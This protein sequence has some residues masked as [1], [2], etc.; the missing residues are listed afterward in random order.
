MIN[1]TAIW[2]PIYATLIKKWMHTNT[3]CRMNQK[4]HS[5]IKYKYLVHH[6]HT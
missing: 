1:Y 3:I 2:N 4:C 5:C 6:M